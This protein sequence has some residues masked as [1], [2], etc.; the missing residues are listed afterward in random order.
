MSAWGVRALA[1]RAGALL[2]GLLAAGGALELGLWLFDI[3]PPQML[4]KR[5]LVDETPGARQAYHCYPTNPH[6]E[7]SATPDATT[8]RWRLMT[9]MLEARRLP[10]DD[11]RDTPWCV[12]YDMNSLGLRE[13]ELAPAPAP[14]QQRVLLIG[15]SFVFGEGV[16][17]DHTLGQQLQSGGTEQVAWINAG[18]PGFGTGDELARLR[19]LAPQLQCRQALVVFT[20]N[21]IDLTTELAGRQK[22]IN[23]LI[24]IRDEY[25]VAD[26]AVRG[27]S[28]RLRSLSMWGAFRDMR[29]ITAQTIDWYRDSYDPAHNAANLEVFSERLRALAQWPDCQ[30]VL[31]LYP[32]LEGLEGTYPLAEVHARVA[33]LAIERRLPVLDLAPFFQ[34]QKSEALWVHPT[35]HHPNGHANR[36][37][38]DAIRRWLLAM[39]GYLTSPPDLAAH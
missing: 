8:G 20:A 35:D 6:G 13:R 24:N 10:L 9:S 36:I 32:L 30:V 21:D 14:G 31:V 29:R 18:R 15:D 33:T 34:G 27:Y 4:T 2:V 11:L 3:R 7:L 17:W 22:F 38:A 19:Q 16:P 25:L 37:A 26:R 5:Y 39:P 28:G 1:L 12:R 23:D